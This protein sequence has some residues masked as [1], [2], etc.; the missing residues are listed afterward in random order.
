MK[1]FLIFLFIFTGC[2]TKNAFSK[3][4]MTTEQELG[5]SSLQSSKIISNDKVNGVIS[6]LYLNEIYPKLFHQEENFFIFF[7]SKEKEMVL[8]LNNSDTMAPIIKL[9][10]KLP[11][12]IKQLPPVNEFSHLISIQ[13]NWTNY[14]FVTFEKEE[15]TRL[16]LVLENC[17]S[18]LAALVFQ[19]D[20]Q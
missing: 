9:N 14:Y 4:D 10:S 18:P 3:F 5:A 6:A 8:D 1:F 16:E 20:E 12:K 11:L 17:Q 19:K 2:A 7:Y 15:T 13:N